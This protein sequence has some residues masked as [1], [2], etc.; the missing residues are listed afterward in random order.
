MIRKKRTPLQSPR[1]R[2]QLARQHRKVQLRQ[3]SYILS[4]M[5]FANLVE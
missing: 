1:R 3:R 4:E 2:I 5:V